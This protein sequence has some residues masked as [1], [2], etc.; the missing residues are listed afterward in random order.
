[1]RGTVFPANPRAGQHGTLTGIRARRGTRPRARCH[2]RYQWSC[3]F[4]AVCPG[5]TTA[6]GLVLPFANTGALNPHLTGIASTVAEG[7][8]A[9]LRRENDPP[10]HF[11]ILLILDGAAWHG[12][13]ALTVPGNISLLH[14]PRC[15]P[16]LNRELN[17]VENVWA[18]LRANRLAITAFD[19]YDS[20]DDIVTAGC[21]AGNFFANNTKV[22]ASLT[23]RS[24]AEVSQQGR[25][26]Q[27]ASVPSADSRAALKNP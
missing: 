21:P 19:S 7:A 6:A 1:M 2:T 25:G 16:E 15:S 23:A 5:R 26:Y 11:L 10:D 22:I 18:C 13:A 3:I 8:H 17:P 4:G 24:C 9:V 20:Y 27:T 12:S 14:L